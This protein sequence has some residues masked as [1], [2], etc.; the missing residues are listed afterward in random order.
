MMESTTSL[1]TNP[2]LIQQMGSTG[3]ALSFKVDEEDQVQILGTDSPR[4]LGS[5]IYRQQRAAKMGSKKSGSLDLSSMNLA[6]QNSGSGS[7][8]Q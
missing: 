1:L 7:V 4:L 6:Y 2:N 8:R 5:E 3:N